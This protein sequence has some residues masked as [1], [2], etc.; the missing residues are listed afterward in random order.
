MRWDRLGVGRRAPGGGGGVNY[1]DRAQQHVLERPHRVC[2][3]AA[4]LI[5]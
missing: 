2:A 3:E 1:L 5:A 4:A